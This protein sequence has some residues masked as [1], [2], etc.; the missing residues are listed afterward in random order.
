MFVSIPWGKRTLAVPLSQLKVVEAD[1][2]TSE[3]VEDWQYGVGR[4]YFF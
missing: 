3:A 2:D 4:G 1:E